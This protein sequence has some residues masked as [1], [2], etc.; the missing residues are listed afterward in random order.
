[1]ANKAA[2]IE[3]RKMCVKKKVPEPEFLLSLAQSNFRPIV[4]ESES[5]E[6]LFEVLQKALFIR[7]VKNS[8]TS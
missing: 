1:M 2:C 8:Q 4:V 5:R 6:R 7:G 3:Y